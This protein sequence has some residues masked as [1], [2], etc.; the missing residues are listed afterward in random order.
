[1][2]ASKVMTGHEMAERGKAK[3][4]AF[5]WLSIK[6]QPLNLKTYRGINTSGG[7]NVHKNVPAMARVS[8]YDT[9]FPLMAE[10]AEDV[11]RTPAAPMLGA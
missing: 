3:E 7:I 4:R 2:F 1:M 11:P 8:L 9:I 5:S 10:G 6:L